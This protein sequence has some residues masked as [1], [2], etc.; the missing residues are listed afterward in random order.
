MEDSRVL[1]YVKGLER[2]VHDDYLYLK[3]AVDEFRDM[4]RIVTPDKSIPQGIVVDIREIH[5]EIQNRFKEIRAIQQLLQGKY[6]QFCRRDPLRDKNLLELGFVTKTTFSRFEEQ[7]KLFTD[8]QKAREREKAAAAGQKEKLIQWFN[9]REKQI[10]LLRK[11]RTLR[12]LDYTP[13]PGGWVDERRGLEGVRSLTLFLVWGEALA[14]DSLQGEMH[15]REHDLIER[16]QED[17]LRGVL[18]HLR[19]VEPAEIEK[20]FRGFFEKAG[21]SNLKCLLIPVHPKE[22]IDLERMGLAAEV[23]KEMNVGEVRTLSI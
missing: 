16:Y 4:C 12:E 11:M 5:K 8:K 15:L 22:E 10:M 13:M 19:E 1:H 2:K 14:L 21:L 17:E 23:L 3:D 6:R 18:A 9:S 20:V 7:I